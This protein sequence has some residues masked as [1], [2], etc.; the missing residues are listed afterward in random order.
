MYTTIKREEAIDEIKHLKS[1]LFYR[2]SKEKKKQVNDQ[3]KVI[4][5]EEKAMQTKV[6]YFNSST[7]KPICLSCASHQIR[8]L[9]PFT[10]YMDHYFSIA[11]VPPEPMGIEH[12][13]GGE[14]QASIEARFNLNPNYKPRVIKFNEQG[15][16]IN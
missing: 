14:I 2:F 13:C 16:V 4:A 3:Q 15:R 6:N 5:E 1:A 11:D 8:K 9:K 12:S 7:F 10:T